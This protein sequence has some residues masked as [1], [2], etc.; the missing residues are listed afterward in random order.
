M[1]YGDGYQ[2]QVGPG[3]SGDIVGVSPEAMGAGV[4]SAIEGVGSHLARLE[5]QQAREK[6]S[7]GFAADRAQLGVAADAGFEDAKTTVPPDQFKAHVLDAYDQ[8]AAKILPADPHLAQRAAAQIAEDRAQLETKADIWQRGQSVIGTVQGSK[9]AVATNSN[10][11]YNDPSMASLTSAIQQSDAMYDGTN[12]LDA[13]QKEAAKREAVASFVASGVKGLIA[14]GD[15]TQAGQWLSSDLATSHLAPDQMDQLGG[16]LQTETRRQQGQAKTQFD[17]AKTQASSA[18][19]L[20]GK[21]IEAGETIPDDQLAQAQGAAAKFG[22]DAKVYD[23]GTWR[24]KSQL[25][26]ETQNWMPGD[27]D[28]E[29]NRLR[30]LGPNA[31]PADQVRLKQLEVIAPER[32]REIDGDPGA[33]LATNG[34][35]PPALDPSNSASWQQRGAWADGMSKALGRPVPL[36]TPGEVAPLT[37]T[38][39]SGTVQQKLELAAQIVHAGP[40]AGRLLDQ[41][42]P[43]NPE[44]RAAIVLAQNNDGGQSMRDA[45]S[46][47]DALK[48]F[49]GLLKPQ[50]D[51]ATGKP[52][53]THQ[54]IFANT[55]GA[56]FALLPP[57]YQAAVF[58][59][60]TNIYASR[61]QRQ[62]WPELHPGE[63]QRS[64]YLALGGQQSGNGWAGGLGNWGNATVVMPRG[65]TS[66]DFGQRLSRA[67]GPQWGAASTNGLPWAGNRAMTSG[68]L[69]GLTPVM[70]R[71]G[72]YAL[73]QGNSYITAQPVKGQP[74]KRY[75]F[76][77]RK[78]P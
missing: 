58:S 56:A 41:V 57:A 21:R 29:L 38:L 25:N 73:R 16:A 34:H 11:L 71:D 76:D 19:E 9:V 70:V 50:K 52:L 7:F 62:G 45:L 35:P 69:R 37:E 44:F 10:R 5:T 47:P 39:H 54:Q 3:G 66:T 53:A 28:A 67:T 4:G 1:A 13:N 8:A 12:L 63:Y 43:N 78:L 68:E 23:V 30:A 40:Y 49:P 14:K 20:L 46:G 48:A 33:F 15:V 27:Y 6:A 72:V 42:S 22:L 64:I 60:T 74:I 75:E 61:G 55:V 36:L 18:V 51:P 65:M 17:L 24:A 59:N 2:P 32:K 31:A 26:T 77:A